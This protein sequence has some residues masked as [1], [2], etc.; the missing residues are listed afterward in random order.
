MAVR[1]DRG[2]IEEAFVIETPAMDALAV[3]LVGGF[4]MDVVFHDD[5]H[6]L[7]ATG[8]REGDVAAVDHRL[9]VGRGLDVV[10]SVAVPTAGNLRFVT[11][12][13]GPAMDAVGIG[14]RGPAGTCVRSLLMAA[15]CH[16]R[17]RRDIFLGLVGQRPRPFFDPPVAIRA[18]E[19]GVG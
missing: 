13:V 16:T 12:E 4:G 7:V 18:G 8:A 17:R 2:E 11:F 19:P 6:V 10:T 5:I 14:G 9:R 3:F 1:A 15:P